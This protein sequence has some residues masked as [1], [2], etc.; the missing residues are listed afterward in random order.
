MDLVVADTLV[1]WKV[2]EFDNPDL[3]VLTLIILSFHRSR[4]TSIRTWIRLVGSWSMVGF[5]MV[6]S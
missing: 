6:K 4:S 2:S 5:E 3:R 1:L